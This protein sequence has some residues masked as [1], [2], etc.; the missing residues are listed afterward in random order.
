LL[1]PQLRCNRPG[2]AG[3]W[4]SVR[5]ACRGPNLEVSANNETAAKMYCED[6]P[7]KGERR[8]GPR[9]NS[10]ASAISPGST[11]SVFRTTDTQ[12]GSRTFEFVNL[13]KELWPSYE[14]PTKEGEA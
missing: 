10:E 13:N 11:R 1:G 8:T 3:E 12:S 9:T 6:F 4:N 2:P 7:T 14:N 5:I